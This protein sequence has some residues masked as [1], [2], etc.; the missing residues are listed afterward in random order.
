MRILTLRRIVESFQ[1]N[2]NE[3]WIKGTSNVI[4]K[5]GGTSSC[6]KEF[7]IVVVFSLSEGE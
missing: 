5:E 1:N 4:E 7:T 6:A 2:K 3:I